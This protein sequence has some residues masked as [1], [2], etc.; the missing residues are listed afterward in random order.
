MNKKSFVEEVSLRCDIEKKLIEKILKNSKEVILE[1]LKNGD[2]VKFLNFGTF[3]VVEKVKR[4]YFVPSKSIFF[5]KEAF[6]EP[7]FKFSKN[8]KKYF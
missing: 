2:D 8:F 6:R 4:T 1:I 7:V 3:R 5:R